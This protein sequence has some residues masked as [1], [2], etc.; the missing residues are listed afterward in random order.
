MRVAVCFGGWPPF[1][2]LATR[3]EQR[4]RERST[5][6]AAAAVAAV[7]PNEQT[8]RADKAH[9]RHRLFPASESERCAPVPS[10]N[11]TG[12]L[13][14][15]RGRERE[16]EERNTGAES[17]RETGRFPPFRA[18]DEAGCHGR[19]LRALVAATPATCASGGHIP[20][21]REGALVLGM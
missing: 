14:G 4:E 17:E 6:T 5:T 18:R 13:L 3:A 7:A 20:V 12:L 9:P 11:K 1:W 16:D 2:F 10:A 21:G 15:G 8:K 19:P